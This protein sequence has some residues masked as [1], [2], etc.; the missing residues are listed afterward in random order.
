[1]ETLR[2]DLGYGARLLKKNPGFAAVAILTLALGIAASTVIFSV[3]DNVLLEP[4]PYASAQRFMVIQVHDMNESD[5]GGRLL[6]STDEFLD[7]GQQNHVFDGVIGDSEA[8]IL[9]STSAG[10]ERFGGHLASPETFEF[11]GMPAFLGRTLGPDDYKPEATPVFVMRYKLWADRFGADPKVLNQTFVLNGTPRILVGIMPSRFAWGDADLWIPQPLTRSDSSNPGQWYLIGRLKPGVSVSQAE[12]DL[13]VIG[14]QLANLHTK[15]YP[16]QFT[17]QVRSL[18]DLVVGRF[19]STL[20]IALAAVALLLAIACGNVANLLL[21]QA[22]TRE[23][24]FAIRSGLGASRLALVRQLLTESLTLAL[25]GAALGLGLAW[26]ALRAIAAFIPQDFIPSETVIQLNGPVLLFT[27]AVTV[28]TTMAFGL[29][30]ALQ[31]GRK[32]LNEALR[33]SAKSVGSGLRHIRMRNAIVVLELAISFSLLVGAGLL[34]RSFVALRHLELGLKAD[35]ILSARIPLPQERYRTANQ[36]A[37]F[38]GPLI[39]RLKAMTGIVGAAETSAVPPYGGLSSEV[40]VA[41][42]T[43]SE[44]WSSVFQLCSEDYFPVLRI[45]FLT[46]RSFT[47]AEVSKAR[48]LAVVNQTFVR[49]FFQKDNPI[50]QKVRLSELTSFPDSVP[51]PW[52]EVVGV[53]ADVKNQGLQDPVLPEVWIPYTITGSAL[54]GI[55]VRTSGEPMSMLNSVRREVWATDSGVAVTLTGTLEHFIN[56][57]SYSQPRFGFLLL[58][59]FAAIGLVLVITGVYGLLAFITVSRT[60]EIGV[61]MALGAQAPDILRLVVW[62]A[63]R[64]ALTGIAIGLVSSIALT[65]LLTGLLFRVRPTDPI[66]YASVAG[67]LLC[68]ALAASYIPAH[69]ATHFDPV[70]ALRHE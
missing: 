52:F 51:D 5:P 2:R 21:A 56:S 28:L 36:V 45:V 41:G 7:F 54:R 37:G 34:M 30:P 47:E 3:I 43:H 58:A 67:L 70:A 49:K 55:L 68:V 38:Y 65:R 12:A 26:G 13:T 44:K 20:F 6:F 15:E 35:H 50:G 31:V 27:V 24:E 17:V 18:V 57:L 32:H 53:V 10:T 1:M 66:T 42:K 9:Y 8:D 59:I 48:R 22:T 69:R 63:G 40:E 62:Q 29:V 23:K 19:R 4:F 61:R 11:L 64:V 46:G 60:R 16:K 25:G 14:R 39:L 33:D